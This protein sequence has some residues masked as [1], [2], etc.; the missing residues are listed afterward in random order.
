MKNNGDAN[1]NPVAMI[2]LGALFTI[3]GIVCLIMLTSAFNPLLALVGVILPIC[4][5]IFLVFGILRAKTLKKY[6][7]L[8]NDPNAYVTDA[9]FIKATV[10]SY[11]SRSVEVGGIDVPTSINIYKK[12]TYSYVDE[13]GVAQTVKSA[14]SYTP[15][16]ADFLQNKGTFKIKCKG[17]LS[18]IIEEV[19][20]QNKRFNV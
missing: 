3:G 4:G 15:N 17:S 8:Y 9:K 11:K 18:A 16:Q 6:K 10:S 2:V 5:L 19:P 12:I 14:W 1:N 13:N 7:E 20:E